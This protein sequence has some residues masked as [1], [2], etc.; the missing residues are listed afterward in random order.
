MT[1]AQ[2]KLTTFIHT[3]E[4]YFS[5]ETKIKI[6]RRIENSEITESDVNLIISQCKLHSPTV[7][8]LLSIFLGHLGID[9]FKIGS[10]G[11]GIL[12]LICWIID[13]L[14]SIGMGFLFFCLLFSLPWIIDIFCI[15]NK[16]REVNYLSIMSFL[17][18]LPYKAKQED[19]QNY[20]Q[21]LKDSP[22][23]ANNQSLVLP[24]RYVKEEDTPNE[25]NNLEEELKENE[26]EKSDS[27]I[28]SNESQTNEDIQNNVSSENISTI[29][30]ARRMKAKGIENSK[31]ALFT[32][33]S[34]EEIEKLTI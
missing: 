33:L 10:I 15:K 9:R 19:T 23:E 29:E 2:L 17:E 28:N 1:S 21:D 20:K 16:T 12:K 26:Q 32:G 34:L 13:I 18:T 5:K 6:L 8:I 30:I 22:N 7:Q 14:F 3:N 31:I 4:N 11:I 27:Q 25:T 24:I